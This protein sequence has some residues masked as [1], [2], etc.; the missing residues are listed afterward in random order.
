MATNEEVLRAFVVSLG[1]KS[2]AAQQKEFVGAIESATLKAN[3]LADGIAEM[4]K[5][6]SGSLNS[7]SE[8]F[9]QLGIMADQTRTSIQ[10]ILALQQA[11]VQF[12]GVAGD[13][14]AVLRA[15]NQN[16]R[17][18]NDGN[19]SYYKQFG[20]ELNKTTGKFTWDLAKGQEALSHLSPAAIT[21]FAELAHISQSTAELVQTHGREM[22]EAKEK[23]QKTLEA[24]GVNEEMA[25]SQA[26]YARAVNDTWLGMNSAWNNFTTA[27]EKPITPE[28]E[29]FNKWLDDH[30]KDISG[31]F[32]EIG[33]A[34]NE[35]VVAPI[36][37]MGTQTDKLQSDSEK[38][39]AF[40]DSVVDGLGGIKDLLDTIKVTF[41][42]VD[43]FS[44]WSQG[45]ADRIGKAS[46]AQAIVRGVVTGPMKAAG[47]SD[48]ETH[49]SGGG[50]ELN[51]AL[52]PLIS[53]TP[54]QLPHPR[55]AFSEPLHDRPPLPPTPKPVDNRTWWQKQKN[56]WWL[57]GDADKP[58]D[59]DKPSPNATPDALETGNGGGFRIPGEDKSIDFADQTVSLKSGG[60]TV[61]S[62][63]PL[64]VRIEKIDPTA[65]GIGGG[66][67]GEGGGSGP[68][69]N[70]AAGGISG[71]PHGV[72]ARGTHGAGQTGPYA[73]ESTGSGNLTKLISDAANRSGVDPRIMEGIRAG[74]S[75]HG[76]NYDFN[77]G[78][79]GH[80]ELSYGPFQL[81]RLRGLGVQF[82]QETEAERK[83]LGLGNLT[84]PRTISLQAD[85]VAKYLK[86]TGGDTSPWMGFHGKRDADPKWGD[87]GYNPAEPTAAATPASAPPPTA[88]PSTQGMSTTGGMSPSGGPWIVGHDGKRYATDKDGAVDYHVPPASQDTDKSGPQSWLGLD[89]NAKQLMASNWGGDTIHHHYDNSDN[90]T[91]HNNNQKYNVTIHGAGDPQETAAAV[92]ST[93]EKS[94][95]KS[96]ARQTFNQGAIA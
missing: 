81:N 18:L 94:F 25:A 49:Y 86:R 84:D 37:S 28:I 90:S 56:L 45:F 52:N 21:Q 12:G 75:G 11:F 5:S 41:E 46:G 17:A 85:W 70:E 63:N 51:K 58:P 32:A 80:P 54:P 62:G 42:W 72:R 3:L 68:S 4:A 87:S 82:E 30:G 13:A 9:L 66:A 2:E 89:K 67:L 88:K 36:A 20:I 38:I 26:K 74:E 83:R 55:A 40:K 6:I 50:A 65:S 48:A 29:I 79:P 59:A 39:K 91:T 92:G 69:R 61:Q 57:G 73:Y 22:E 15:L 77:P 78:T 47:Q 27:I 35:D 8:N 34:F 64:P 23:A 93:L 43:S 33:K 1:W 31:A 14:D 24:F 44:K 60:T 76:R 71:A 10:T 53:V 96:Q 16:T 7:A 19:L 95:S